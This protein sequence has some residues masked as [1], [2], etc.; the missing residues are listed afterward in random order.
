MSTPA[1]W[2]ANAPK[3]RYRRRVEIR[4]DERSAAA[5]IEDDA[6][7]FEIDLVHDTR[8]VTALDVAAVRYPYTIC[9]GAVPALQSLVGLPLARDVTAPARAVQASLCCTHQFDSAALA[10]AQ[11][12]RGPGRRRYDAAVR[13]DGMAKFAILE[14]DGATVL[15]WT[16]RADRIESADAADGL[17]VRTVLRE[18]HGRADDD[19]VE[20]L[21]VMRRALLVAPGRTRPPEAHL[22]P[23]QM[24]TRMAGA[25]H[26]FQPGNAPH[27]RLIRTHFR[28]FDEAP[29]QLLAGWIGS[30]SATGDTE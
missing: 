10:I 15:D 4:A 27:G 23:W 28:D 11:A 22:E 1:G 6:H 26:S 19:F 2:T 18:L 29:D 9:P 20:A 25:C 3:G 24:M 12:A 8:C 30:P 17:S 5:A 14:C 16:V 13:V 7:R 21:F